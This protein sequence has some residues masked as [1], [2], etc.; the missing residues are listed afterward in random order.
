MVLK[1]IKIL[2]PALAKKIKAAVQSKKKSSKP[3]I[4]AKVVKK[5]VQKEKNNTMLKQKLADKYILVAHRKKEEKPK[6]PAVPKVNDEVMV[7]FLIV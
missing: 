2:K 7:D 3:Q 6:K 5:L 1:K 4:K